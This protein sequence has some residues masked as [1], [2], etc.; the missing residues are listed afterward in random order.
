LYCSDRYSSRA[1]A[2]RIEESALIFQFVGVGVDQ[3]F[4][5]HPVQRSASNPKE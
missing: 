5:R 4:A 1:G 3:E 2:R